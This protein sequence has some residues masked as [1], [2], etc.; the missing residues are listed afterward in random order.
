MLEGTNRSKSADV[1]GLVGVLQFSPRWDMLVKFNNEL[2][3]KEEMN[4]FRKDVLDEFLYGRTN[5]LRHN[6]KP[7][8]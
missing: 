2:L 8:T 4:K 7:F 6:I 1:E 5:R 3:N